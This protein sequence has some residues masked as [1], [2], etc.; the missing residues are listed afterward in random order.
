MKKKSKRT[1]LSTKILS[2]TLKNIGSDQ[3][4]RLDPGLSQIVF[5]LKE[6][7]GNYIKKYQP[8]FLMKHYQSL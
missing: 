7:N 6:N 3:S 5:V 1:I 8:L 4:N 2:K